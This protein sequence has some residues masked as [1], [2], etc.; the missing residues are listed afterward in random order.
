MGEPF[1]ETLRYIF[2]GHDLATSRDGAA[3]P[4]GGLASRFNL[5]MDTLSVGFHFPWCAHII[6][7]W[8]TSKLK[9]PGCVCVFFLLIGKLCYRKPPDLDMLFLFKRVQE[10]PW[11]SWSIIFRDL[12][13]ISLWLKVMLVSCSSFE[14]N[15]KNLAILDHV[16]GDPWP[17]I[18]STAVPNILWLDLSWKYSI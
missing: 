17:T 5:I 12:L 1:R 3:A 15:K 4:C 6:S 13:C 11:H 9:K 14:L 16:P 18:R 2:L 10:I 7:S 8:W